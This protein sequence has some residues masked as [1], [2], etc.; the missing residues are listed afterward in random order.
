MPK[1]IVS[2]IV[3]IVL[4]WLNVFRRVESVDNG[5]ADCNSIRKFAQIIVLNIKVTNF[6]DY[7]CEYLLKTRGYQPPKNREKFLNNNPSTPNTPNTPNDESMIEC[8]IDKMKPISISGNGIIQK[9]QISKKYCTLIILMQ[10]K[11]R[12]LKMAMK[13]PCQESFQQR[14]F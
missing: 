4:V 5:Y 14:M 3:N 13:F 8:Q 11:S 6:D 7:F 1:F 2:K 10:Y 9:F 12:T